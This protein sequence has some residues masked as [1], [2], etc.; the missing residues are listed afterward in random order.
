MSSQSLLSR[1]VCSLSC[2]GWEN[3]IENYPECSPPSVRAKFWLSSSSSLVNNGRLPNWVGLCPA[4][5]C[6]CVCVCVF[7]VNQRWFLA[8]IQH[9][10][11]KKMNN[12]SEWKKTSCRNKLVSLIYVW[13]QRRRAL[14][15]KKVTNYWNIMGPPKPKR[16]S[17]FRGRKYLQIKPQLKV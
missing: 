14:C 3:S 15:P 7:K 11:D 10:A 6:L 5:V 13:V 4:V 12:K 1:N 2:N 9:P 16:F 8:V 17:E